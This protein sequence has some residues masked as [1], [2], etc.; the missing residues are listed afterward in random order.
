MKTIEAS[1]EKRNVG[2]E[3]F[4]IEI[5]KS[6]TV[7]EVLSIIHSR[8]EK[9]FVA[10]VL[11]GR[12]DILLALQADGFQFIETNI[13][14]EIALT[15]KPAPPSKCANL[16][17]Y[18]GYHIGNDDEVK[19]AI[20]EIRKGTIF[21][22]DKVAL[23]PFFSQRIAGQRYAFWSEDVMQSG[24]AKMIITEYNGD[25]V[26]FNIIIDKGKYYD[27]FLGGLYTEYLNS[28][29][30]FANVNAAVN[31]VFDL[32]GRKMISGVSSNNFQ[33]LKLHMMFGLK[34]KKL[35]YNLIKH[36]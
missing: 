33:M 17:R 24:K 27:G 10:K 36:M 6:D 19:F 25:N 26:G 12:T 2:V 22:T 23:D 30:G 28:G 14:T 32:G 8:P 9:Y 3:C 18:A 29:L 16:I 21:A 11:A 35:T 7:S 4:E 15:E 20:D 5:G 34:I 13:Q 31:A 1:W